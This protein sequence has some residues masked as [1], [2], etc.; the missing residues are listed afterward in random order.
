MNLSKRQLVSDVECSE[1]SALKANEQRC[2]LAFFYK[3]GLIDV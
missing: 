1:L 3:K 2:S